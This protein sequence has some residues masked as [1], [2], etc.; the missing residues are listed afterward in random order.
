M[1]PF[2][3]EINWN[4]AIL[5]L[6]PQHSRTRN[7]CLFSTFPPHPTVLRTVQDCPTP[8]LWAQESTLS[9]QTVEDRRG[10]SS[11]NSETGGGGRGAVC[12]SGCLSP[13]EYR[14]D[15]A[16]QCTSLSQHQPTVKRVVRDV[17][18]TPASATDR[19]ASARVSAV[20]LSPGQHDGC[21]VPWREEEDGVPRV[22]R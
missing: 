3:Q 13:K 19:Y 2:R 9:A 21:R 10:S 11:P 12:A 8:R 17:T 6:K 14:K 20:S 4:Q 22:G 1:S 16:Q 5:P 7:N 18:V 15:S